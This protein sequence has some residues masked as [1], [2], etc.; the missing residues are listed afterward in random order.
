MWES[1]ISA[2]RLRAMSTDYHRRYSVI[3]NLIFPIVAGGSGRWHVEKIEDKT[4]L[5]LLWKSMWLGTGHGGENYAGS[6]KSSRALA[7][8]Q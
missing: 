3:N 4:T 1:I 2:H 6:D 7:L 8:Q 5:K